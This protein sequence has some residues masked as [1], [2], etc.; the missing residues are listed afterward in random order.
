MKYA[1]H[2]TSPPP[3]FLLG[4]VPLLAFFASV[5]LIPAYHRARSSGHFCQPSI[6][7]KVAFGMCLDG[8][9]EF[10]G[11]CL[12]HNDRPVILRVLLVQP[13]GSVDNL[14]LSLALRHPEVLVNHKLDSLHSVSKSFVN[15]GSSL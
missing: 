9:I 6:G 2:I 14:R 5:F 3:A 1:S 13:E 4:L 7:H 12:K 15:S 8:L 11:G 10:C